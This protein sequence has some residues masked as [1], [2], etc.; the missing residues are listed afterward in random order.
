M[1]AAGRSGRT[2][3]NSTKP[4]LLLLSQGKGVAVVAAVAAAVASEARRKEA[5]V[6]EEVGARSKA[7]RSVGTAVVVVVA[8]V[9]VEEGEGEGEG[10]VAVVG[11]GG[12]EGARESGGGVETGHR[13]IADKPVAVS[14]EFPDGLTVSHGRCVQFFVENSSSESNLKYSECRGLC[15]RHE[16]LGCT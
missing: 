10:E 9:A 2:A 12:A 16:L 14:V 6:V 13:V 8:A 1:P 5:A 7:K 11:K 15:V 4:P 3:R